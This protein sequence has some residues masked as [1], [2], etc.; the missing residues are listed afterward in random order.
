MN[1]EFKV[2][3][4]PDSEDERAFDECKTFDDALKVM[5]EREAKGETGSEFVRSFNTNQEA[6][7]Y[8]DGYQD[9][10]GYMGAGR[11]F[12]NK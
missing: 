10:V 6:E 5:V 4:V 9:G 3:T 7:A 12:K 8:V 1:K 2:F 11:Y